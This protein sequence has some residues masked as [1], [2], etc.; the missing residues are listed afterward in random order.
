MRPLDPIVEELHA[1]REAL[2]KASGDDLVRIAEAAR[3]R[4]QKSGHEIVR[5]PPKP[6][7]QP[8]KAS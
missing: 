3:A 8:Q 6:V 7:D 5:L 2:A 1:V 4:Q